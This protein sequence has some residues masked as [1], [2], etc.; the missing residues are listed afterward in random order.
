MEPANEQQT[1]SPVD[2]YGFM[3]QLWEIRRRMSAA[4]AFREIAK[5]LEET[6]RS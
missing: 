4:D 3:R 2:W 1:R 5:E 6:K